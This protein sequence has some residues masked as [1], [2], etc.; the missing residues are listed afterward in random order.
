MLQVVQRNSERPKGV[1]LTIGNFD[2]VHRG[3]RQLIGEVLNQA[4][5][6]GGASLIYTFDP[7]PLQVLAPHIRPKRLFPREDLFPVL[8]K[9]GVE[10]VYIE[11]FTPEMAAMDPIQFLEERIWKPFR[12]KAI[13]VGYDFTFGHNRSGNFSV[14][15]DYFQS[16]GAKV[17]SIGASLWDGTP[18]SSTRIRNCLAEGR[19][20]EAAA[21]LD[22][23][24]YMKGEVV[25]GDGRGRT[26]GVP[27]ANIESSADILPAAGVYLTEVSVDLAKYPSLTNIGYLPTFKDKPSIKPRVETHILVN[28]ESRKVSEGKGGLDFDPCLYGK[29]VTLEF[30]DRLRDEMKFNSAE[31]L[32]VQIKSDQARAQEYFNHRSVGKD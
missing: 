16:K 15:R 31:D 6:L 17:S 21:L 25:R 29:M 11:Q 18:V 8:E 32:L 20:Q 12:P 14:L 27:T 5:A 2:G 19:V 3:H 10:F 23:P 30:L 9:M 26:I 28:L 22:R 7:H 1:V 4:R 24:F 13:V